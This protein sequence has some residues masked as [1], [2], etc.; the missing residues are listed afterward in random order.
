MDEITA[1]RRMKAGDFSGLES[2]MACY[3][4][5]A[6]RT[7]FLITRDKARAEDVVQE[8]FLR[9][10]QHAN[11]FDENRPFEPYLMRSVVNAAL[12][13]CRDEKHSISFEGNLETV[14]RL[15][16]QAVSV[17]S[18]TEY[19]QL[20][21]EILE[22]LGKLP[23]RQRAA[24]VQRYYLGMSEQEMALA[25]EAAPGTVKWLLNSARAGLRDLIKKER[26]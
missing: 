24:I 17:E 12:N 9:L 13:A 7:A 4:V 21:G 14:E 15:V 19:I 25:L 10:F 6:V 18:Q 2:L 16:S 8:V 22:A 5:K 23:S 11:R 26:I 3:Q 1:I 20:K